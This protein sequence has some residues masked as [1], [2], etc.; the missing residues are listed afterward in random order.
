MSNSAEKK[1]SKALTDKLHKIECVYCG[2]K[3]RKQHSDVCDTCKK[4]KNIR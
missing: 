2:K 3:I 4:L 1:Q